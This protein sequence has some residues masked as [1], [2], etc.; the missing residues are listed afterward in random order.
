MECL[1]ASF[2]S[3]SVNFL[4]FRDG[5]VLDAKVFHAVSFGVELILEIKFEN[6]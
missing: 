4:P 2:E 6:K 1:V 5:F 3:A